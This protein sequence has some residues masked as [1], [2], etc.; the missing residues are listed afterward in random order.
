M[1]CSEEGGSF[2]QLLEH[3]IP[4]LAS[5]LNKSEMKVFCAWRKWVRGKWVWVIRL[6][7]PKAT[8]V[9]ER[10]EKE[11]IRSAYNEIGTWGF[12]LTPC[13]EPGNSDSPTPP[14]KKLLHCNDDHIQQN[15]LA[16]S[17]S[18]GRWLHR[19][20]LQMHMMHRLFHLGL[21]CKSRLSLPLEV[22]VVGND[23]P[24]CQELIPERRDA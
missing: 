9:K 8:N 19:I 11:T 20:Q 15:S 18:V 5:L 12:G 21:Q 3:P 14:P 16:L 23:G 22:Q 2:F 1:E 6:L 24:N 4:I 10:E 17:L 13:W 7:I